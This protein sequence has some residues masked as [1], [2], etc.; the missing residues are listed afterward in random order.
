MLAASDSPC[1]SSVTPGD[2]LGQMQGGMIG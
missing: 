2:E 1:M